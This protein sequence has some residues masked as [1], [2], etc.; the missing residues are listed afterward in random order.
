MYILK[1][2][3]TYKS[4]YIHTYIHTYKQT[5]LPKTKKGRIR[6]F[7]LSRSALSLFF[8][9]PRL[10]LSFALASAKARKKRGCP[11]LLSITIMVTMDAIEKVKEKLPVSWQE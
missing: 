6:A 1:H 5:V 9:L 7:F 10:L 3:H 8:A 11:A 4:T 2:I